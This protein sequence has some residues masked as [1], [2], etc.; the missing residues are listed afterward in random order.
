MKA[1]LCVISG[2]ILLASHLFVADATAQSG[3]PA[4]N[5]SVTLRL[6]PLWANFDATVKAYGQD[7]EEDDSIDTSD[8]DFAISGMWRITSRLQLEAAYSGINK[9]SSDFLDADINLGSMTVP[10]GLEIDSKFESQV[11]RLSLGYAFLRD[12]STEFGVDLSVNYTTVKQS[13]GA[14]EPGTQEIKVTPFDVSEPLPTVGLFFNYAFSPEWYLR[15]NVGVFAFDIGDIDGTI[16][17]FSGGVEYRP[18]QHVGL[19]LSYIYTSADLT[20]TDDNAKTDIEYDYNGPIFYL[21]V[22]F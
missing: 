16:F 11:L 5:E 20:I 3:N 10:A 13:F 21:V 7:L 14:T 15:S 6:G 17:D 9:E 8:M 19:G 18:W 4:L 2:I 12:E 22:G 1:K